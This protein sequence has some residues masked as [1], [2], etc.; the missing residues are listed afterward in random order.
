MA[1]LDSQK[2]IKEFAF[3]LREKIEDEVMNRKSI[4]NLKMFQSFLNQ[5]LL[6]SLFSCK[7]FNL[8]N[9]KKNQT[10]TVIKSSL[11]SISLNATSNI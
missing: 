1:K 6:S 7:R 9:L 4:S 8:M 5:L 3:P 10:Y 11:Q 2:R